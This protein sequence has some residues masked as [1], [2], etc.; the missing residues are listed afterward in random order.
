MMSKFLIR[1]I[2]LIAGLLF[3]G[4]TVQADTM[5]T[6]VRTDKPVLLS[7]TADNVWSKAAPLKV[8][9]DNLPYD[10]SNGYDG[11]K[12]TT[13]TLK[14]LYDDEYIYFLLQY[15]DPTESLARFPW[16]KQKDGTW[17]QMKNKDST[18]HDNTYYEDKVGIFWN[19]NTDGFTDEG[20]MIACHMDIPDPRRFGNDLYR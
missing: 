20:C 8:K 6:S 16:I 12:E 11:M 1:S 17:K 9:L 19:I 13:V 5:L 3:I 18:G 4:T 14:S 15:D 2:G 10:P 7:G